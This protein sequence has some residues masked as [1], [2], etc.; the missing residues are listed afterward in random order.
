MLG[1]QQERK[2]FLPIP[3]QFLNGTFSLGQLLI[4]LPPK[5]KNEC[6]KQRVDKDS[7]RVTFLLDL[8][9]LGPVR[10]D[11]SITGESIEGR[12]LLAK[13]ETK[14]LIENNLISFARNLSDKGFTIHRLECRLKEP[15]VIRQSL[16]KEIIKEEFNNICL[17]A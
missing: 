11:L 12:F 3:I 1:L 7:F 17:V 6:G 16:V 4:H 2:I 5:D 9:N 13:E 14:S 8:S 10:A 15:G